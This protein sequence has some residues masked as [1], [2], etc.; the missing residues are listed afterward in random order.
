[1]F[2]QY[3]QR[4]FYQDG[5]VVFDPQFSSD[6][7]DR[8]RQ[9]MCDHMTQVGR[10]VQDEYAR[11]RRIPDLWKS[12][13]AVVELSQAGLPW[14]RSA[15]NWSRREPFC[16]QTL[17]FFAGTKQAVHSDTI[18]FDCIPAGWMCGLWVALEDVT[19]DAGPLVVYPGTH[20][21]PHM[22]C[23]DF[24]ADNYQEYEAKIQG[25]LFDAISTK[26]LLLKGEAVLW[27]ANLLHGGS[28]VTNPFSTRF[29]QVSHYFFD[30][31]QY[32][33]SNGRDPSQGVLWREVEVVE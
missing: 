2:T 23:Y 1:M 8:V 30:G 20:L 6:L 18:H 17:N 24:A 26:L 27:A 3:Q 9:D 15:F 4:K 16:F 10:D 29:S 11:N 21:L 14:V 22:T 28:P 12:S 31:C 5:Y 13:K 19:P 25:L 33:T 7:L 32:F